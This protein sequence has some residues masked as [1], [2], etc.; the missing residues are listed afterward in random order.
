M[1]EIDD[2][3]IRGISC[4]GYVRRM[5]RLR[6]TGRE[7]SRSVPPDQLGPNLGARMGFTGAMYRRNLPRS[8]SVP[9]RLSS[10]IGA[11]SASAWWIFP[12]VKVKE[13]GSGLWQ[14]DIESFI[15][16]AG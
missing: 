13:S 1:G 15:M 10:Q 3:C 7:G 9:M 6:W 5:V 8:R 14:P 4:S 11:L 12:K 16:S 2:V